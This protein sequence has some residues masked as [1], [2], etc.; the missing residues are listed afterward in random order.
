MTRASDSSR[1]G[2]VETEIAVQRLEGGMLAGRNPPSQ[3]GG[4]VASCQTEFET[5]R[6]QF[7][8]HLEICATLLPYVRKHF[9]HMEGIR[10]IWFITRAG[11]L[12]QRNEH[13]AD[14]G[15]RPGPT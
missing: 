14:N 8:S 6:P 9:L 10:F 13:S 2:Y 5:R 11:V 15:W 7:V 3:Q 12:R 4:V 1:R